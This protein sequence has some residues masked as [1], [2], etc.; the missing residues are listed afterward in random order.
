MRFGLIVPAL[1]L[2][3]LSAC[4]SSEPLPLNETVILEQNQQEQLELQQ[5]LEL[6]TLVEPVLGAATGTPAEIGSWGPVLDWPHVA[7]S[8]ATLPDGQVLTYSGSERRTWPTTEQTYS[9]VWN[10]ATGVF[11]ENLHQG[12]NMFCAAMSMTSDGQVLVNGGRNQGNSPWTTLFDYKDGE[13]QTIENMASG[14]RWYPT[15]LAT[16]SGQ[17]LTAMGT[18]TNTRNPDLWDPDSG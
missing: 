6:E 2:S 9:A 13:W 10:P 7:V 4:D 16:G 17:V 15:S 18:S 5:Q 12:H 14:G 1:V 8:M 11:Q 3:V